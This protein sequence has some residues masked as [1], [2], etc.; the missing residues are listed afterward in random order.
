M[1]PTAVE[2]ARRFQRQVE[3]ACHDTGPFNGQ[4]AYTA[5]RQNFALGADNL[6]HQIWERFAD[7]AEPRLVNGI[8]GNDRGSFRQTIPFNNR[9]A[10]FFLELAGYLL[11]QGG[12]AGNEQL[13]AGHILLFAQARQQIVHGGDAVHDGNTVLLNSDQ[14]LFGREGVQYGYRR[15]AQQRLEDGAGPG[16]TVIHGQDAQDVVICRDGQH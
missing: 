13:H 10:V 9:F 8:K 6:N 5:G 12:A 2:G 16:K 15:A 7:G 3:I 14:R 11:G 1:Q 4:F